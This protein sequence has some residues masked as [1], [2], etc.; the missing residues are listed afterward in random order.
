MKPLL[1]TRV[2]FH[3]LNVCQTSGGYHRWL[4]RYSRQSTLNEDELNKFRT[5]ADT[6][7]RTDKKFAPL[8]RMNELR[9]PFIRDTYR[10]SSSLQTSKPLTG[11][12]LIGCGAGILA[13]PLAR[14]G[15]DVTAIDPVVENIAMADS[16]RMGDKGVADNLKYECVSI[17]EFA[18]RDQ[19]AE[20][21]DGVIASEVVEH[22]DDIELF[23]S[24]GAKC[25]K[26]GG[27]L[28]VTTINQ[29]PIALFAAIFVAEYVLQLVPKGIHQYN[30]FVSPEALGDLLKD[31]ESHCL[32]YH[33]F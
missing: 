14:L 13:E 7:W 19:M 3:K 31:C 30:R 2:L 33:C 21:F 29:T 11:I 25:L 32:N 28:F 4:R 16:H 1:K 5:F 8:V 18:M 23:V 24:S 20:S 9:V 12:R 22:V 26:S 15:A 6:D 27:H 17:E 10:T